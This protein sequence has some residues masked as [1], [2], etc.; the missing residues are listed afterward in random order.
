M[1]HLNFLRAVAVAACVAI[2]TPIARAQEAVVPSSVHFIWMG[3]NDCPPCVAW[4]QT[5][6]P[7]LQRSPEFSAI[8]FSYVTKAIRSPVPPSFFLPSE[9]KPYKDKLDFASS[10]RDGSPQA[11]VI[12]NGEVFDYFQGTRTA[13][14][15]E[16]MLA[17]IRMGR[18]YPF[19]RCI[20]ASTR[21]KT[22]EVRG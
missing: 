11:A 20:K 12:V 1:T 5:E 9:V 13:E 21:W 3:G 14:E 8:R 15:I 17:A 22:C 4:R 10:G 18:P 2:V 16:S 7:K 19:D 6:L